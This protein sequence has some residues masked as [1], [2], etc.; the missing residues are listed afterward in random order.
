MFNIRFHFAILNNK[1]TKDQNTSQIKMRKSSY[2]K[3][4]FCLILP[5]I[6]KKQLFI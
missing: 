1:C 4:I 6:L 3:V 2:F 5:I